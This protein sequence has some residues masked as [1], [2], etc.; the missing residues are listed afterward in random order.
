[1]LYYINATFWGENRK[2]IVRKFD[3]LCSPLS[4]QPKHKSDSNM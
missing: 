4:Y 2:I 1:M 3:Q